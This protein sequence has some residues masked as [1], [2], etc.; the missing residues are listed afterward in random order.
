M[1]DVTTH[2]IHWILKAALA[3]TIELWLCFTSSASPALPAEGGGGA[4]GD[5]IGANQSWAVRARVEPLASPPLMRGHVV[6]ATQGETWKGT[7]LAWG[8][9]RDF[10]TNE[11]EPAVALLWRPALDPEP[12]P[13]EQWREMVA[14][15]PPQSLRTPWMG[16][17]EAIAA[18]GDFIAIGAPFADSG[19]F[20]SGAV[21]LYEA[22]PHS[23]RDWTLIASLTPSQPSPNMHF[24][25]SLALSHGVLAVGSPDAPAAR[26][27]RAGRVDLFALTDGGGVSLAASVFHHS[28]AAAD[29]FGASVDIEFEHHTGRGRLLVGAPWRDAVDSSAAG[30][31][32]EG[33]PSLAVVSNA[34]DALLFHFA[35]HGSSAGGSPQLAVR[36]AARLQ[37]PAPVLSGYFGAAVALL[38]SNGLAIGEP[39]AIVVGG[40]DAG[41]TGGLSAPPPP[42]W[43]SQLPRR[44]AV[45]IGDA[46]HV[47]SF[48]GEPSSYLGCFLTPSADR[49]ML[50]AGATGLSVP[51]P[52]GRPVP[53]FEP[54]GGM[55]IISASESPHTLPSFHWIRDA[56]PESGCLL[57]HGGAL[58]DNEAILSLRRDP[59]LPLESSALLIATPQPN[60]RAESRVATRDS[61]DSAH[62]AQ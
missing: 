21:F 44:G 58:L 28:P 22:S 54:L 55:A 42:A 32:P 4:G 2:G 41:D 3:T 10:D 59:E 34:G 9:A 19:A 49:T 61:R 20:Q 33:N 14:L 29:R 57:G 39:R 51:L 8:P 56:L 1:R 11:S 38:E 16:F 17:G 5:P 24:G 37:S 43:L 6:A 7:W 18:D 50:L 53:H 26:Q 23:P 12:R 52:P 30:V 25:M 27:P 46:T 47:Q 35:R 40:G 15:E 60:T 13:P 45:H 48:F 62:A 31:S 36:C